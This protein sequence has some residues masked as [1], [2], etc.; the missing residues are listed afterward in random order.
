[1]IPVVPIIER[2]EEPYSMFKDFLAK[3]DKWVLNPLRYNDLEQLGRI[4]GAGIIRPA[5][6]RRETLLAEKAKQI[7]FRSGQ[8]YEPN[9]N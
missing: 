5:L 1:M 9:S 6:E 7:H 4:T 2:D 8:D 3:Y